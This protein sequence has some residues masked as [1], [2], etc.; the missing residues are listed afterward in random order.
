MTP[1]SLANCHLFDWC[2]GMEFRRR[3]NPCSIDSGCEGQLVS[4]HIA[5]QSTTNLLVSPGS[6]QIRLLESHFCFC[7]SLFIGAL[8]MRSRFPKTLPDKGLL[9]V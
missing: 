6:T 8:G 7:R 2:Q 9:T 4:P 3:Q 1:L 5:T